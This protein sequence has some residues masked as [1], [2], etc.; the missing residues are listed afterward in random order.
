[1]IEYIIAQNP[2]DRILKRCS[3]LLTQGKLLCLPTDTNWVVICDPF[4]KDAVE[5]LYRLKG[6]SPQKHFSLLCSD[7]S[8][9]SELAI[10]E[11]QAFK[12]LKK[13]VP[14]HFTF[15]FN[16]SKM[17]TKYLKASKTDKEIGIR[18]LVLSKA[19]FFTF[20]LIKLNKL[21]KVLRVEN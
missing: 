6:E 4:N 19:I 9:A 11:N 20:V 1:M 2:D 12:L 17:I 16:A 18:I 3:D 15:I 7:I 14:G 5:Q 10:I 21:K 13:L 8:M